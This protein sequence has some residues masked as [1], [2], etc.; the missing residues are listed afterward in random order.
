[1]VRINSEHSLYFEHVFGRK[2][3]QWSIAQVHDLWIRSK[4][5]GNERYN[6]FSKAVYEMMD[7]IKPNSLGN[8][9][10][11][12]KSGNKIG[13][14]NFKKD[15]KH[16]YVMGTDWPN[17]NGK[18]K[19][20]RDHTVNILL[21]DFSW[22]ERLRELEKMKTDL[23]YRVLRILNRMIESQ[24]RSRKLHDTWYQSADEVLVIKIDNRKYLFKP[25]P[26][27]SKIIKEYKED[28]VIELI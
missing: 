14:Y 22:G 2:P 11:Y 9:I 4:K 26:G 8:Y 1:M 13:Q 17:M 18:T 28:N 20:V 24:I 12:F 7:H 21:H 6:N 10:V 23:Q 3:K 15:K 5:R 19:E 16:G 25:Q 27:D